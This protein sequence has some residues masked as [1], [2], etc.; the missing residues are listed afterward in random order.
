MFKFPP[1]YSLKR[2]ILFKFMSWVDIN[3]SDFF[4]VYFK[5]VL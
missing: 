1:K 2:Q 4:S 3:N 5:H